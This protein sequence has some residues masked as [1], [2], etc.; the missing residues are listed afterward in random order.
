[1]M[2]RFVPLQNLRGYTKVAIGTA[3]DTVQIESRPCRNQNERE[4]V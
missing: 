4:D 2:R 3:R 1:M